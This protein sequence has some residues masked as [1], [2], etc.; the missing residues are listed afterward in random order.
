M[1]PATIGIGLA[2]LGRHGLRYARHL[3]ADEV[4]RARLAAVQRRD[5]AA[6]RAWAQEQGVGFHRSLEELAADRRVD[7]VV[8]VLPPAEHPAAVTAA[9]AAGKA[10]LIEKPLAADG[11]GARAAVAAARRAGV[12][13]VCAQ[14]LRFDAVVQAARARIEQ[15]GRLHLLAVS[16]RFEPTD[17]G[18][19]DDPA[20][21][22]FVM[23]TAVHGLD[24]VRHLSGAEIVAAG[25]V[26]ARVRAGRCPDVVAASLR[27][28]PG[29]LLATFDNSWAT[30]GRSGRI[31]ICG[32]RGQLTGD[33]LAGRLVHV[34]GR[35]QEE[36]PVGPPVPT[37][38]EV[39]A[40]T[41][42]ALADDGPEPVP[43]EEGLAA[44]E[45]VELIRRAGG[46]QTNRGTNG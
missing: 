45:A 10:L 18:W 30:A 28:E 43:L 24:L 20:Q 42:T 32:E 2:G 13:A 34:V 14:T 46:A 36:I 16:Q 8:A 17:R 1:P 31:E 27:L 7:L 35:E 33:L 19:F 25:G 39:L 29:P 21:G 6:G 4:P 5:A 12:F 23:N 9:G 44:V 3:L 26:L 37:V 22:G 15:L 11:A 38:R 41:V 40:A